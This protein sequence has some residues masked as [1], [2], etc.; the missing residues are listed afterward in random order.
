MSTSDDT[1]LLQRV[2]EEIQAIPEKEW[3]NE[4]NPDDLAEIREWVLKV[5]DDSD[6]TKSDIDL[7]INIVYGC[8]RLNAKNFVDYCHEYVVDDDDDDNHFCGNCFN[9]PIKCNCGKW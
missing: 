3:W 2:L 4:M 6:S 1:K 5:S 9:G 8:G 7:A